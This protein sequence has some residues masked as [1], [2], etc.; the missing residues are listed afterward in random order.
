MSAD[1]YRHTYWPY[2]RHILAVISAKY[3]KVPYYF[4]SSSLHRYI[5]KATPIFHKV[6][7]LM[8]KQTVTLKA[9]A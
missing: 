8:P 6:Y 4:N 2:I 1:I 9:T 3:T 5:L 7:I